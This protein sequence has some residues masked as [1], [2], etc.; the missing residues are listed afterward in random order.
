MHADVRLADLTWL[1]DTASPLAATETYLL[2]TRMFG[3]DLDA[4]QAWLHRSV[5]RL[6]T[7]G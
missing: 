1:T 7:P 6:V 4:Y 2:V 3:W 5:G